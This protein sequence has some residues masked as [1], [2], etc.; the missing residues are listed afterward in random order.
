MIGVRQPAALGGSTLAALASV[1]LLY[2]AP[3]APYLRGAC[4]WC[5]YLKSPP[6]SLS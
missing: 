5:I 4:Q 1:I 3:F 2:F 6:S